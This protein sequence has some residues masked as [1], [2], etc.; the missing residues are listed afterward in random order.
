MKLY[1]DVEL[2]KE[3]KH[4]KLDF[5]M[6]L[7]GDTQEYT[8]YVYNDT[9]A[10]LASLTFNTENPEVQVI[11]APEKLKSFE[12]A[13]LKIKWTPSITLKEGLKSHLRIKGYEIY[14]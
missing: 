5:G 7:A 14:S 4:D 6:V 3:V 2:T 12:S 13:Q 10:E 11:E 9:T 1:N 8:Y